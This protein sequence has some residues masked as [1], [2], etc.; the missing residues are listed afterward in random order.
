[1]SLLTSN[2]VI[3]FI[4]IIYG[5]MSGGSAIILKIGIFRAGGIEINNF[6]RDIG[7]AAWRLITTPVWM[8]GGIAAIIGFVIYTIALNTYDVS[9]VKPL[10]NT[11]LLFTFGLAYLVFNEKLTRIEWFGIGILT[12]G[13]LFVAFS[14]NIV[15]EDIMNIPLLLGILPLT[16]VLMVTMV[17][18]MFVSKRGHA[19]F[20]FP[21]FAGTFYGLGTL[22]TKSLLI[23]LNQ[24][25]TGDSII[26]GLFLY[27]VCMLILTYF[28][29]IIA[30]ML[31]FERGRLSIVSPITNALS[32]IISFI[33][34]YFVFYENLIPLIGDQ[35]LFQSLFKIIGLL[36]ILAA[37]IILRREITPLPR[38]DGVN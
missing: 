26:L 19:E 32:V 31:A 30:Q 23:A 4:M 18:I 15:S 38:S 36:G 22:F 14:P 11:N 16:I 33:G 25:N 37:L 21:I 9:V 10:V 2:I 34:A 1:M 5:V 17:F 24:M 13:L 8:L 35:F 12:A 3:L 7:P 27:S 6:I 20:V 28:F 29:A